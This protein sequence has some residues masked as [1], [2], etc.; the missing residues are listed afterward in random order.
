MAGTSLFGGAHFY[1][2][3]RTFLFE[4]THIFDGTRVYLIARSWAAHTFLFDGT[5][6]T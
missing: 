6:L 2:T 1:S 5:C 4:S 3:E